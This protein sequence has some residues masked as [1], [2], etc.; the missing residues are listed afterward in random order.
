MSL[1]P[2]NDLV[3]LRLDPPRAPSTLIVSPDL[4]N[5][6]L[7]TGTVLRKGPGRWKKKVAG[8]EKNV[9]IPTTVPIGERVLF[10]A[11]AAGT[12]KYRLPTYALAEDEALIPEGDI[13]FGFD[14]DVKVEV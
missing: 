13:L 14:G 10:F 3:L 4:A 7:R 8:E 11:A 6:P 2:T 1:R 12:R 5:A 9:F